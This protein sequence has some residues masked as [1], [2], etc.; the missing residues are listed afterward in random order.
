[1]H[2]ERK[3]LHVLPISQ[4]RHVNAVLLQILFEFCNPSGMVI[5]EGKTNSDAEDKLPLELV[6]A[7]Q[8]Y[9]VE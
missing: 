6:Y 2:G 9:M 5:N 7:G 3:H 8:T 1:M 4:S